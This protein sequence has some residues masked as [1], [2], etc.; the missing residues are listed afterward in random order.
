MEFC[1][2]ASDCAAGKNIDLLV[3]KGIVSNYPRQSHCQSFQLPTCFSPAGKCWRGFEHHQIP[4]KHFCKRLLPK[5]SGQLILYQASCVQAMDSVNG[6]GKK[7]TF[8]SSREN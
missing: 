4:L 1:D 2:C 3:V 8:L 7:V 5:S 6:A